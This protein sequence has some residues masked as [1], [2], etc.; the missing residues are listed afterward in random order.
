MADTDK[1]MR[2][3][4]ECLLLR[5]ENISEMTVGITILMNAGDEDK[6]YG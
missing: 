6:R 4:S 1:Q 2:K 3:K 5:I